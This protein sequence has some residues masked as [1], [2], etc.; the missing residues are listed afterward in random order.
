MGAKIEESRRGG[1]VLVSTS[2]TTFYY[3]RTSMKRSRPPS[4]AVVEEEN[5]LDLQDA[6]QQKKQQKLDAFLKTMTFARNNNNNGLCDDIPRPIQDAILEHRLLRKPTRSTIIQRRRRSIETRYDDKNVRHWQLQSNQPLTWQ[7]MSS[8]TTTI[9]YILQTSSGLHWTGS[10]VLE[11]SN[12]ISQRIPLK[13]TSGT[14][15]VLEGTGR[16]GLVVSPQAVAAEVVWMPVEQV[17]CLSSTRTTGFCK[18]NAKETH[19]VQH[20][21]QRIVDKE[22]TKKQESETNRN[23]CVYKVKGTKTNT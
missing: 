16:L 10:G 4:L 17:P 22:K 6:I 23:D 19:Q 2:S 14:A 20:A 21:W 3:H 13:A 1:R 8:T 9:L 7:C 15:F 5:T 11:P 12:E 18:L